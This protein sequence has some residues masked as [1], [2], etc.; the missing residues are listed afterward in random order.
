[1][2]TKHQWVYDLKTYGQTN[3]RTDY[4]SDSCTVAIAATRAYILIASWYKRCC[5]KVDEYDGSYTPV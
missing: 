5:E 1:M 2:S 4:C 3:G